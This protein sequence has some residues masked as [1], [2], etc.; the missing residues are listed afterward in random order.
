MLSSNKKITKDHP[1]HMQPIKSQVPT[2][3][4]G[5]FS[6]PIWTNIIHIKA[7][8]LVKTLCRERQTQQRKAIL[9]IKSDQKTQNILSFDVYDQY[10]PKWLPDYQQVQEHYWNGRHPF[11]RCWWTPLRYDRM[12]LNRNS[13]TI[14]I[15]NIMWLTLS[16]Y[17]M[18][19]LYHP[20]MEVLMNQ[21]WY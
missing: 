2:H 8:S 16:M 18:E 13:F 21:A 19:P 14:T 6:P 3:M 5:H 10:Y 15:R 1:M 12:R 20:F 9:Q 4:H 7:L 11:M 17:I